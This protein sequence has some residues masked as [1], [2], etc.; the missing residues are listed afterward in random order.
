MTRYLDTSV[1]INIIAE[2]SAPAAWDREE[3]IYLSR[4]VGVEG[5][6]ALL[7]LHAESRFTDEQ[8]AAAM[9][10]MAQFEKLAVVVPIS[11]SVSRAASGAFP[12]PLRAL[13]AIHLATATWARQ[14]RSPDITFATH[15][16]QLAVAAQALEFEVF[17]V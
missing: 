1:V 16:R 4:L 5:R 10:T 11:E 15:D 2:G 14:R 7:R 9:Q 13:D 3:P 12:T 6:R 8:L 17:G